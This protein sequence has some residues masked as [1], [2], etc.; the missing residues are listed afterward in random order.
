[1]KNHQE[2]YE[3]IHDFVDQIS[4]KKSHIQRSIKF[5]IKDEESY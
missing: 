4:N 3:N 2:S 5:L 1:M